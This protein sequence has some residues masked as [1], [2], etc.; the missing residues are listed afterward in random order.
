MC[1]GFPG[2]DFASI[3]TAKYILTGYQCVAFS[4]IDK[5]STGDGSTHDSKRPSLLSSSVAK[6]ASQ[7]AGFSA[8]FALASFI[9]I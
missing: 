9:V 8:L 1:R 2:T 4:L 5:V 6:Y 7:K 3:I